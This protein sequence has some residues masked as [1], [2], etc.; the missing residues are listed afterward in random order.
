M[1]DERRRILKDLDTVF[2]TCHFLKSRDRLFDTLHDLKCIGPGDLLHFE[3]HTGNPVIGSVTVRVAERIFHL[4]DIFE[5]DVVLDDDV[6][7]LLHA[8]GIRL[9]L[10]NELFGIADE[11]AAADLDILLFDD[12]VELPYRDTEFIQH[13]DI[14]KYLYLSVTVPDDIDSPHTVDLLQRGFDLFVGKEH[15]VLDRIFLGGQEHIDHRCP[16]DVEFAH[17][18]RFG[19]LGKH[20][21]GDFVPYIVGRFVDVTLQK[22]LDHDDR[23]SLGTGGSDGVHSPDTRDCLFDL[24]R[25]LR[26][27]RTRL[28][29]R[30]DGLDGDHGKIDIGE[31][32]RGHAFETQPPEDHQCKDIH[33]CRNGSV[34]G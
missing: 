34:Y 28:G 22:E 23:S 17:Q 27:Y 10:E 13:P 29:T 24:V 6:A 11:L 12:L 8:Q 19:I 21:R 18:R 1:D 15:Q 26:L 16:A 4:S 5:T 7:K 25:D 30:V 3:H 14:G 2:V 33:Q 9:R 32:R 20:Y 31:K